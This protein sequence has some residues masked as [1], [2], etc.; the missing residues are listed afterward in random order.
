MS[1]NNKALLICQSPV[2]AVN[3]CALV[4]PPV[5]KTPMEMLNEETLRKSV[6]FQSTIPFNLLKEL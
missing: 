3:G 2:Y 4:G 5:D 6:S 1:A